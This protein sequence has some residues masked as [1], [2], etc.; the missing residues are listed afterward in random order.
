MHEQRHS[1]LDV[2]QEGV[3][4]VQNTYKDE[5]HSVHVQ[6][7]SCLN[8]IQEGVKDVHTIL[9]RYLLDTYYSTYT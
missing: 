1:C 9:I 8:V 7:H 5:G 4:D 3:K 6:K 2:I